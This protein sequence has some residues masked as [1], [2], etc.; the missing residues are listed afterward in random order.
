MEFV[1]RMNNK[2]FRSNMTLIS[3]HTYIVGTC[4]AATLTGKQCEALCCNIHDVHD[5]FMKLYKDGIIY[6]TVSSR[7]NNALRDNTV[8]IFKDED[9]FSEFGVIDLFIAG[10]DP[11]VLVYKM[12]RLND[13]IL[14]LAGHPCRHSLLDYQEANLLGK[15]VVPV[16]YQTRTLSEIWVDSII[17]KA[18]IVDA[19]ST[20]YA[21]VQPNTFE[22]H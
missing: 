12:T 18:V 10:V 8:C 19:D 5:T 17:G 2:T 9:D 7:K 21:V 6:R 11:T 14:Q 15:Y 20:S 1:N 3:D 13:A 16:E 22:R 4:K